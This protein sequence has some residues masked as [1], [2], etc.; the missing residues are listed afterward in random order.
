MFLL[1]TNVISE[2]RN[3]KRRRADPRFLAWFEAADLRE[4]YV[5][6][7]TIHEL[8]YG[9][10]ILERRDPKQAAPLRAWLSQD[11]LTAIGA[12]VLPVDDIVVRTAAAFRVPDPA[13]L[14]DSLIAAT[15]LIHGLTVATRN[16]EDFRF[17]GVAVFNPWDYPG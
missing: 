17:P 7:I 15:A 9:V 12:S 5:S 6:A 2:F 3:I 11:A 1:D 13:P 10:L 8:E 4:V 14:A 16:A